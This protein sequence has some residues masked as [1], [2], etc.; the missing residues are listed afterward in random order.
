MNPEIAFLKGLFP[1]SYHS[2]I[3]MVVEFRASLIMLKRVE[4]MRTT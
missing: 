4:A 1:S 3:V 2:R